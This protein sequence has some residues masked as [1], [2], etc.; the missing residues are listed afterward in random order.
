MGLV[1]SVLS[2]RT[3]RQ[4]ILMQNAYFV[5]LVE[6]RWRKEQTRR[7]NVCANQTILTVLG[8]LVSVVFIYIYYTVFENVW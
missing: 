4:K 2:E 5:V 7:Y 6:R 3:E 1:C 8:V